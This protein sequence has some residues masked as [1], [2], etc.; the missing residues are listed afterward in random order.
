MTEVTGTADLDAWMDRALKALNTGALRGVL[1][2]V[3]V[4]VRRRN[5]AR[6]ARQVAPDGTPWEPRKE[7]NQEKGRAVR[8]RA[9]MMRGLRQSRR[10]RI[11]ATGNGVVIGWRGRDGRI[12][13]L[14]HHGGED[15]V[16][17][18][19]ARVADYP[20]RPLLGLAPEDQAAIRRALLQHLTP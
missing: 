16:V 8:K 20:A 7:Q 10:L 2:D 19:Q 18:G 17:E 1:R 14:H 3:A 9:A 13:A 12:A 5:Q 6:M 15:R 4:A 11:Q